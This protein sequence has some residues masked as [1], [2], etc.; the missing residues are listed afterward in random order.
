MGFPMISRFSYGFPMGF[1]ISVWVYQRLNL[2]NSFDQ[3]LQV[4]RRLD[5]LAEGL[6]NLL[7][8]CRILTPAGR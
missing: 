7:L 6:V 8:P 4:F 3:V 1:P 2:M 5:H